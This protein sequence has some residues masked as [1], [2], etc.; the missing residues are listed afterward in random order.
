M[1]DVPTQTSEYHKEKHINQ[2]ENPQNLQLGGQGIVKKD[3]RYEE[4]ELEEEAGR[5]QFR[6]SRKEEEEEEDRHFF[7]SVAGVSSVVRPTQEISCGNQ[8][9]KLPS[10]LDP[11]P[12]KF[13]ACA[14]ARI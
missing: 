8:P 4:E 11:F 1:P 6:G 3:R 12:P 7:S 9:P 2:E 5:E 10:S 13:R 14:P